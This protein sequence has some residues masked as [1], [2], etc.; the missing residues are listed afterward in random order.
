MTGSLGKS[1]HWSI[2]HRMF[3][4]ETLFCKNDSITV[5]HLVF[6][7]RFDLPPRAIIP[8]HRFILRW[9]KGF[10]E[11][12][13]MAQ[14]TSTRGPFMDT[15]ENVTNFQVSVE[16]NPRRSTRR[17]TQALEIS[18]RILKTIFNKHLHFHPYKIMIVQKFLSRDYLQRE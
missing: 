1:A 4:V 2:E 6:H 18:R 14:K 16:E 8:N 7:T 15:P 10:R 3:T 13:N 11:H 9:V 5:T 12:G 17:C